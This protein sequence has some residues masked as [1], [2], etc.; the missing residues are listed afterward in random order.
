[1]VRP[2]PSLWTQRR[3]FLRGLSI[4]IAVGFVTIV[5]PAAAEE[6]ANPPGPATSIAS[7]PSTDRLEKSLPPS[8]EPADLPVQD[9]KVRELSEEENE[10]RA[11]ASSEEPGPKPGISISSSSDQS[12]P[13]IADPSADN[14][15]KKLLELVPWRPPP[16][17]AD[18]WDWIQLSSGEWLKGTIERMRDD[19]IEFDSDELDTLHLDWEDVVQL[20]SPRRNVYRFGQF[21]VVRGPA[22]ME[23]QVLT[24]MVGEVK[25]EFPRDDLTAIVPG[26][27]QEWDYWSG[28]INVSANY[29]S[30]NTDQSQY[31]TQSWIRRETARNRAR[32]DVTGNYGKLNGEKNEDSVRTNLKWDIYWSR[33]FYITPANFESFRDG[34]SNIQLRLTPSAGIGYHIL[35]GKQDLEVEALVGYQGTQFG[36]VV[37][38][39]SETA[40][41]ASLTLGVMSS[42]ELTKRVDFDASYRLMVTVPD[43]GDTSHMLVTMLSIELIGG[44]SLGDLDLDIGFNLERIREPQ[45]DEFGEVPKKNDYRLTLGLGLEF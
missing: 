3:P 26:A 39:E 14:N 22:V 29:R 45:A 40:Q 38:G 5:R 20:R 1:M 36:S 33:N 35:R 6:V 11:D 8:V 42:W 4:A 28:N 13:A 44:M 41:N 31:G 19:E 32:F 43:V 18:R 25:Q 37:E 7:A 24:V 30:G 9:S 34:F 23:G 27:D 17:A 21:L 10:E 15:K 2:M 12:K 16:P